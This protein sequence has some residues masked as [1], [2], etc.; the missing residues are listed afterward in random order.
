MLP[1]ARRKRAEL[2]RFDCREIDLSAVRYQISLTDCN[3]AARNESHFRRYNSFGYK[4]V[5]SGFGR[6]CGPNDFDPSERG[7]GRQ[8]EYEHAVN[9]PSG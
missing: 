4:R 7:A 1:I 5:P 6:R 2:R 3:T 9:E 8:G